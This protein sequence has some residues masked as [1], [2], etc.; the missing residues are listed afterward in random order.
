[1][2]KRV[3]LSIVFVF[4]VASIGLACAPD[5]QVTQ[6]TSSTSS[7][8]GGGSSSST[9]GSGGNGAGNGCP[10]CTVGNPPAC[11]PA[12]ALVD[13]C[14]NPGELCNG[15]GACECGLAAQSMGMCPA[16]NGWE[17]DGIGGCIR[18]CDML[19]E[20]RQMPVVCPAGF[21]CTIE[22]SGSKSCREALIYCPA[23]YRCTVVCTGDEACRMNSIQCSDDGPCNVKCGDLASACSET[24][25][26]CGDNECI[27]SCSGVTKPSLVPNASC[28][29]TGC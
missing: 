15:A 7:G 1:M 22:C 3:T 19:D 13:D 25:V 28:N 16:A 26:I 4:S 8:A 14:A 20:C 9:S 27:S 24:I 23:G 5:L 12:A 18:K 29:A 21:D 2:F 11:V 6:G 17:S 10:S